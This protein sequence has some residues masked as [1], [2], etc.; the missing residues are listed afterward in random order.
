[1]KLNDERIIRGDLSTEFFK[2]KIDGI[3]VH[4]V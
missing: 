2:N 1:M 4:Y 3:G